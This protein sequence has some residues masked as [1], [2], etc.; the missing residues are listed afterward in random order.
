MIILNLFGHIEN[1]SYYILFFCQE[2]HDPMIEG[3][4]SQ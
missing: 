1:V 3:L 4:L 2:F